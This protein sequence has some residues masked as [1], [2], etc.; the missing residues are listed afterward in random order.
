MG[1]T[2]Y[3]TIKKFLGQGEQEVGERVWWLSLRGLEGL[4][5]AWLAVWGTK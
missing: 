3:Y 1:V 5:G 4:D 2:F